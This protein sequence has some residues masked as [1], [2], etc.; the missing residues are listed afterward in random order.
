MWGLWWTKL[1][2]G[3][4]SASTSVSPANSHSTGCST[5]IICHPEAGTIEQ[6]VADVPSGLVSPQPK[7]LKKKI[8]SADVSDGHFVII[9][10]LYC[11]EKLIISLMQLDKSITESE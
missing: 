8:L 4:F 5:F 11:L 9:L 6:L 10:L 1:N 7:K 3:R 2:W